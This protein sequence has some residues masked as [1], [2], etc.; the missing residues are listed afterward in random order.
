MSTDARTPILLPTPRSMRLTGEP[1]RADAQ[2]RAAAHKAWADVLSSHRRIES[3]STDR[4]RLV[5]VPSA[6]ANEREHYQLLVAR[7]SA[8]RADVQICGDRAGLRHGVA[9][10]LQL[11]AQP[12]GEL[13]CVQIDDAPTFATRGVMLDISRDR[14]PTLQQLFETIERLAFL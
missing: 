8:G 13:P 12:G 4:V 6:Q 11:L 1:I 14:V 9:T 7:D 3:G 5:Q 2:L 10:L